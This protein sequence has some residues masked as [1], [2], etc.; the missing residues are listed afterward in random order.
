MHPP[1]S[2]MPEISDQ[3][4]QA[5]RQVAHDGA[6]LAASVQRDDTGDIIGLNFTGNGNGGNLSQE[7][8]LRKDALQRSLIDLNKTEN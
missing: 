7:T 3:Q 2:F 8:L 1:I 6:A 4:L 5:F